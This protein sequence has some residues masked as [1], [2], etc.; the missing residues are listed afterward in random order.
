MVRRE[1]KGW[2]VEHS[3]FLVEVMQQSKIDQGS[4]CRTLNILKNH[5]TVY[6]KWYMNY[7]SIKLLLEK[8]EYRI[9]ISLHSI[10]YM[11]ISFYF[12]LSQFYSDLTPSSHLSTLGPSNSKSSIFLPPHLFPT[13]SPNKLHSTVSVTDRLV[14]SQSSVNGSWTPK[15]TE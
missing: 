10:F 2:E 4:D 6:F 8:K 14:Y 13:P 1:I 11:P 15:G 9:F 3:R 5:W 7:I 12:L